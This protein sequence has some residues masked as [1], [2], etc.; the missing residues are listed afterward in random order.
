M[1]LRKRAMLMATATLLVGLSLPVDTTAQEKEATASQ[2]KA[3]DAKLEVGDPAP[4]LKVEKFLKG[5]PIKEFKPGHIYVVEFWATW[6]GPCRVSMPHLTEL[7]KKFKDKVT[8]VSVNVAEEREYSERTL[9]KVQK[10]VKQND[11]NMGYTVA[12][13]GAAKKMDETY[14]KAAGQNG[15]PAAFIVT[16]DAKIAFIGHP[17]DPAFERTIQQLVDGKFDMKDAIAAFQEEHARTAELEKAYRQYMTLMTEAR[18]LVDAGKI[19]EGVAKIDEAA[20]LVPDADPSNA[21]MQKYLLLLHA[22][23]YDRA[24]AIGKRLVAGPV[25]DD[26]SALNAIAWSVVDPEAKIE[27][28]DL[29]LAFKAAERAVELTESKEPAILDTLA[30]CYWLK[31][32]KA[33]AIELQAKAVELCEVDAEIRE[34]LQ[35]T[36]DEYKK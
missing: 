25:K 33:K 2:S 36:L 8:F 9:A 15:I 29:A 4:P 30:R 13:D 3:T 34:S 32:N 27:K 10:F 26:P 18:E 12:Y 22:K 23:Q 20:K 11:E 24:Y 17:Q 31:G 7:Q 19:D 16:P 14:M 1:F 35:A 6:C 5:D 21:E 28:P